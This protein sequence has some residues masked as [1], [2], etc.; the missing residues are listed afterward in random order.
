MSVRREQPVEAL[1]AR[2][3]GLAQQQPLGTALGAAPRRSIPALRSPARGAAL[4]ADSWGGPQ[5]VIQGCYPR[6]VSLALTSEEARR[7]LQSRAS[8]VF[9][10]PEMPRVIV[11]AQSQKC[12]RG[13]WNAA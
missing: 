1:T 13:A 8:S 4:E 9:R 12:R 3:V 5:G 6:R 10:F 11:S 2:P 7:D